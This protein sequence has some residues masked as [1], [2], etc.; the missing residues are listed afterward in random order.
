MQSEK[1]HG[2]THVEYMTTMD[3]LY[4]TF[5]FLQVQETT[6]QARHYVYVA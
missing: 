6:K 2:A 1:M 3:M 5:S 4:N